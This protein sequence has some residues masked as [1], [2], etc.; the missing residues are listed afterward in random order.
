MVKRP[1]AAAAF[2]AALVLFGLVLLRPHSYEDYGGLQGK[3]L[4]VTGKVYKKETAVNWKGE[5]TPVLYIKSEQYRGKGQDAGDSGPPG[6]NIIC[7][8][9][10]G[11][12]G[13]EIGSR[14][15]LKGKVSVFERASNPGQFDAY[16]YYQIS[17]ISYRL[18]QA[19]VLA[20]SAEYSKLG[21]SGYRLRSF[22]SKKLRQSLP[23]EEASVM[24]TMLLGEKSSLDK[25]LK[26]LYLRS[27]IAHILAI[28]GL[29]I[30]MLGMGL[31]RL[32]RKCC[33]PMKVSAVVSTVV[34]VFY[35]MMT[36]F[37]VS[38]LRAVFMFA[39]HMI[40]ILV[41]RTYDMLTAAALAAILI[42]IHQPFYLFHSGF[43]FSFGCVLGIGLLFPVLIY[44]E[45]EQSRIKKSLLGGLGMAVINLPIYLWF[46]YQYPVCSVFLNLLVIPLMSLLMGAGLL[47]LLCQTVCPFLS[48]PFVFLIRAVL[49]IYE[50]ACSLCD[51]IP[52][53]LWTPG[54][55][56]LYQILFY[57]LIMLGLVLYGKKMR[58]GARWCVAALGAALFIIY[59][60]SGLSVTF[61]DVGQGDCIFIESAGE[62]NYLVD[63][64]SSSVKGVGE[65]RIIPFLKFQGAS[66]LE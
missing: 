54:K 1:L 30:S 55:P 64:G 12:S 41:E 33:F 52:G 50:G 37:P 39:L 20:K 18:N 11:Q 62:G 45:D 38:A 5:E 28:S 10:P 42:I 26:A 65:Y 19:I 47:L 4:T 44:R 51:R 56:Q 17:G 13:P 48:M 43:V 46:Y 57:L 6:G 21:E 25:E 60:K 31:Y 15:E 24:Q 61:L 27:G 23:E 8:L 32:L 7:Y 22:L 14:T 49:K 36:G 16:S 40:S 35:G 66:V 34:I 59:P 3:T 2:G 53:N 29:H 63:G 9:K 58:P